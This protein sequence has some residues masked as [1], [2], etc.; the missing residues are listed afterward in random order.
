M[1]V[2]IIY[3]VLQGG[4]TI[5]KLRGLFTTEGWYWIGNGALVAYN[6]LFNIL[7]TLALAYLNRECE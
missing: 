3:P 4:Q 7:C 6:I 5:L 1:A 2:A